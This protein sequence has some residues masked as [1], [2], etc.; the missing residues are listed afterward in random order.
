[1]WLN[2]VRF[3]AS[4]LNV[5][6]TNKGFALYARKALVFTLTKLDREADTTL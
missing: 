1:M 5:G 4:S 2:L 3:G 6:L